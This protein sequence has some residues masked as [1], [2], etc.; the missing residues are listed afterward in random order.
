MNM[1]K[2]MKEMFLEVEKQSQDQT[3]RNKALIFGAL[4]C[5][6]NG[7]AINIIS[8]NIKEDAWSKLEV[9]HNKRHGLELVD[10]FLIAMTFFIL[11][12]E[13]GEIDKYLLNYMKNNY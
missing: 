7:V 3:N 6:N 11:C 1:R 9:L 5:N 10:D 13:D 4:I 8:E 2:E 12:G